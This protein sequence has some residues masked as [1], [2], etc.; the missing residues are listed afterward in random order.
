MAN[1]VTKTVRRVKRIAKQVIKKVPRLSKLV[2]NPNL[3]RS[4]ACL[5]EHAQKAALM[6]LDPC[7]AEL[8]PAVYRGDQGYKTR[9][10]SNGSIGTAPSS[11]ACAIVFTP[12]LGRIY[13]VDAANSQSTITWTAGSFPNPG[14]A[15]LAAN[16]DGMRSLGACISAFPS[17]STMNTSGFVYCGLVTES[18]ALSAT[19]IDALTQLCNRSA[20]VQIAEPMETKFVPGAADEEYQYIG[21]SVQVDNDNTSIVMAFTGYPAASGFRIRVTNVVEWKPEP[22]IGIA[23]QSHLGNPSINTIEHV[24]KCLREA[25]PHW[26]SN[27]GNIVKSTVKGYMS[28]GIAGAVFGGLGSLSL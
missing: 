23:T 17:S 10:V 3:S 12:S 16:A 14:Q 25:D 28:G 18:A 24:K 21:G 4:L 2:P 13:A 9:F 8:A 5:D 6:L 20:R 1:K 7:N 15:F 19:T 26:F 27:V 22:S 11:T